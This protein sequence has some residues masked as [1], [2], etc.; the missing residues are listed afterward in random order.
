[1]HTKGHVECAAG[2]IGAAWMPAMDPKCHIGTIFTE[3]Y[4]HCCKR[5]S[6]FTTIYNTLY[7]SLLS[8]SG[9]KAR[10]RRCWGCLHQNVNHNGTGFSHDLTSSVGKYNAQKVDNRSS[11]SFPL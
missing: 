1:M 7:E 2:N 6:G 9:P 11:E 5:K 8:Y 10:S 4:T 3:S